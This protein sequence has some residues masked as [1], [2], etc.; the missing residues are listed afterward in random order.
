MKRDTNDI[1]RELESL[2]D[3]EDLR[4]DAWIIMLETQRFSPLESLNEA[5][6]QAQHTQIVADKVKNLSILSLDC[7]SILDNFYPEEQ[8]IMAML[9]LGVDVEH[10]LQYKGLCMVRFSQ[11]LASIAIHPCWSALNEEKAKRR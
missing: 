5:C 7:S 6:K 9:M 2:T 1:A 4:Q 3:D 8:N 10:I 11:I